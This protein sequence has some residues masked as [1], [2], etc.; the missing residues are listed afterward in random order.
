LV[1]AEKLGGV[2]LVEHDDVVEQITADGSD[3]AFRERI[4][5]RA[6]GCADHLL[7]AEGFHLLGEP[8]SIDRITIAEEQAGRGVTREGLGELVRGPLG[9]GVLGD[10]EVEE[11]AALVV[12]DQEA[13]KDLEGSRR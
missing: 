8:R 12:D 2:A 7:D 5:P 9:G 13:S 10:A 3:D 11:L 1:V 6:P 4:L